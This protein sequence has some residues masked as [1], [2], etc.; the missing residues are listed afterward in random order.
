MLAQRH[1]GIGGGVVRPGHRPVQRKRQWFHPCCRL[2]PE[3]RIGS[4]NHRE[5]GITQIADTIERR[6]A[7]RVG[8]RMVRLANYVGGDDERWISG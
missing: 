1:R 8:H 2:L 6:T 3:V 5:S 4:P 7:G